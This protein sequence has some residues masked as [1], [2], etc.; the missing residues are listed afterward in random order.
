MIFV[1]TVYSGLV[2][3]LLICRVCK[4]LFICI[5]GLQVFIEDLFAAGL[6]VVAMLLLC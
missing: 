3:G 4:G 1:L 5:W 2:S 6:E